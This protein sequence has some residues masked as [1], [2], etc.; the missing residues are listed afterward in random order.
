M[1]LLSKIFNFK[2]A[3]L[4]NSK[5]FLIVGL[6]NIGS[7]YKMTRHNVGFETLNYLSNNIGMGDVVLIKGSRGLGLDSLVNNLEI[8]A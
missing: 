7:E 4:P 6:G 1:S 2:R 3:S 8:L 5:K